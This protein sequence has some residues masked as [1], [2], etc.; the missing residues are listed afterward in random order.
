MSDYGFRTW[1]QLTST[2]KTIRNLRK[3]RSKTKYVNT[4]S[5]THDWLYM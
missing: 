3:H 5:T 2:F 1:T 4:T